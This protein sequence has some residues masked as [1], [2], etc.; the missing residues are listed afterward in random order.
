MAQRCGGQ[1]GD[2]TLEGIASGFE[3]EEAEELAAWMTYPMLRSKK[4]VLA[5]GDGCATRNHPHPPSAIDR[6]S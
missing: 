3:P 5:A 6:P 2:R 1:P 4:R